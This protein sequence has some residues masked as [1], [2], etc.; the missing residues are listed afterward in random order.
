MGWPLGAGLGAKL[1]APDKRVI[2][3]IGDGGFI[4]GCP[5]ATLW[6]ASAYNAPFLTIICNNQT[7]N[8]IREGMIKGFGESS[9]SGEMGFE[10]GADIKMS[11]DY[12]LIA[13][14]CNAYGQTVEDPAE[15]ISALKSAVDHVRKGMPAVVSVKQ[16][17]NT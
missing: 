11:P 13:R 14:A 12:A 5:V 4:Y 8:A 2:S 6:G 9:V 16:E 10:I 17:L 1:A 7:Y 3:L 15:L